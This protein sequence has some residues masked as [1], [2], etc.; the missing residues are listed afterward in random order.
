MSVNRWTFIMDDRNLQNRF[1]RFSSA[2]LPDAARPMSCRH[3]RSALSRLLS[4]AVLLIAGCLFALP[5]V[6]GPVKPGHSAMWYQPERDGEGW[7]LEVLSGD[8]ALLYWY[9]YDENGNQ[10]WLQAVGDVVDEESGQAIDFPE[11]LVT[12]GAEFGPGFDPDDVEFQDVG[13]ASMHF[14]DPGLR[15]PERQ[16]VR[17]RPRRRRLLPALAVARRGA[18]DLVHLRRRGQPVLADRSRGLPGRPDRL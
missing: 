6:S 11:L 7:V 9:T 8:R 4:A 10:R 3:H 14:E 2:W 13:E 1:S 16:L 18:A 12:E 15:R 5:A 17:P